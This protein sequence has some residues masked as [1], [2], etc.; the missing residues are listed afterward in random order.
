MKK[1][2]DKK[3]RIINTQK[4]V[5]EEAEKEEAFMNELDDFFAQDASTGAL[6]STEGEETQKDHYTIDFV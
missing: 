4:V 2:A 5:V 1:E 6:D 3:Q